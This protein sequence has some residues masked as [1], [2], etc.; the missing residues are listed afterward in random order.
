M[1][2]VRVRVRVSLRVTSR[3]TCGGQTVLINDNFFFA[4]FCVFILFLALGIV[5][6]LWTF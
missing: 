2:R 3:G 5:T 6:G 1:I 4:L